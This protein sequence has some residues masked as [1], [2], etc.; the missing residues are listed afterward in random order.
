MIYDLLGS[1]TKHFLCWFVLERLDFT[2]WKTARSS[3]SAARHQRQQKQLR[4]GSDR[5]RGKGNES[6]R[7]PK[8]TLHVTKHLLSSFWF[9]RGRGR[10]NICQGCILTHKCPVC[11][12]RSAQTTMCECLCGHEEAWVG[13]FRN[14]KICL[15]YLS[16][17][18]WLPAKQAA[19]HL[20]QSLKRHLNKSQDY[21]IFRRRMR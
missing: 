8:Q 11:L 6:Q 18:R 15:S 21:L 17:F 10:E 20:F 14:L 1:K 16:G 3:D 12:E 4:N 13:L 5:D 7:A 19:Q 2:L 9:H